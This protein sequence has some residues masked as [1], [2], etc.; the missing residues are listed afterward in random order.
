MTC[1]NLDCKK[2]KSGHSYLLREPL[3]SDL[4][5]K[6]KIINDIIEWKGD[7]LTMIIPVTL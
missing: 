3:S 2:K 7:Q 4:R 5:L 6:K 1:E